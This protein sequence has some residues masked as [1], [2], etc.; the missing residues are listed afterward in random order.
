MEQ[1][2]SR[3]FTEGRSEIEQE[4]SP[5]KLLLVRATPSRRASALHS[6]S[7][8]A[9]FSTTRSLE[10]SGPHPLSAE[11]ID[12]ALTGTSPGNY[13]LGYM[14]GNAFTVFYGGRSDSD[15][16]QRLHEWVGRT[17]FAYRYAASVAAA[18]EKKGRNYEFGGRGELDNEAPPSKD[19]KPGLRSHTPRTGARKAELPRID[20]A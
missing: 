9:K 16:R 12:E 8:T 14:E 19:A 17:R 4:T 15:V 1:S 7:C 5:Q 18:F 10:M 13:A 20:P 6:S 11:A 3:D 2:Q